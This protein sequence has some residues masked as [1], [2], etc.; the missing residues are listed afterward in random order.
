[1]NN[2]YINCLNN[3]IIKFLILN[4]N[5]FDSS[6][7]KKIYD[8]FFSDDLVNK[9]IFYDHFSNL[10][11]FDKDEIIRNILSIIVNKANIMIECTNEEKIMDVFT[12]IEKKENRNFIIDIVNY[13]QYGIVNNLPPEIVY[14]ISKNLSRFDVTMLKSICLNIMEYNYSS[15]E[16]NLN[17]II[18]NKENF[19]NEPKKYKNNI[20]ELLDFYI[21]IYGELYY[22]P[23]NGIFDVKDDLQIYFI[24]ELIKVDLN[25]SDNIDNLKFNLFPLKS[26]VYYM[27]Y[28]YLINA[29]LG[30][31][32]KNDP[33]LRET[34]NIILNGRECDK[35]TIY[36]LFD[37]YKLYNNMSN[38]EDRIDA[39][40]QIEK[41][42]DFVYHTFAK[43]DIA[44]YNVKQKKK[45]AFGL[46]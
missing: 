29:Y 32:D 4:K 5:T 43:Y 9:Q 23:T 42:D 44:I 40:K 15:I 21:P 46:G 2:T 26:Y 37:C 35:N 19:L 36:Y 6:I 28:Q 22:L 12:S 38:L 16:Y 39:I 33:H 7:S 14:N 10:D 8:V 13:L 11:S 25:S 1:M 24:F 31:L 20:I 3:L 27:V 45:K 30:L 34:L 17:R 18:N 41:D